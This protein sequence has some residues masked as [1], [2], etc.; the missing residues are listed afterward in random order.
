[1][2][3]QAGAL[4]GL[5]GRHRRRQ[6]DEPARVD[7]E[8]AHGLERGAAFSARDADVGAQARLDRALAEHVA[9]V[10]DVVVGLLGGLFGP[11]SQGA[12]GLAVHGAR[13]H[14]DSSSSG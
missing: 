11:G 8:A 4:A 2:L 1:V 12:G 10:E 6:V 9:E 3:E 7:G 14:D 5:G 13:G